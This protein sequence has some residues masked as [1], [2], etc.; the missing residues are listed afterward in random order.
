MC[1]DGTTHSKF[2]CHLKSS[3]DCKWVKS[4]PKK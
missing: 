2:Y 3:N 4:E 1:S